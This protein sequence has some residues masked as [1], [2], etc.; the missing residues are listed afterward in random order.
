[1]VDLVVFGYW[2][3][4]MILK[5]F[6]DLNYSVILDRIFSFKNTE[7]LTPQNHVFALKVTTLL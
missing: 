4:S 3:D 5:V 6:S 2:L 7:N 1:V